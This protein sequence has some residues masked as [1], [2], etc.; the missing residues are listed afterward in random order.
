MQNGRYLSPDNGR[1][2]LGDSIVRLT[3]ALSAQP[4]GRGFHYVAVAGTGLAPADQHSAIIN[5][6]Q[7]VQHGFIAGLHP[8]PQPAPVMGHCLAATAK[9]FRLE[10]VCQGRWRQPGM[11]VGPADVDPP[12]A[13]GPMQR[14]D[15][16]VLL[17]VNYLAHR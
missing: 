2:Q 15:R 3:G 6:S 14:L 16:P 9:I 4:G 17:E 10:R 7:C 13:K 5:G 1:D 8:L 12:V 11:A